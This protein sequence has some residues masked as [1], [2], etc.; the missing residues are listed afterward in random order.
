MWDGR[1]GHSLVTLRADHQKR[2][3][4]G[5]PLGFLIYILL[6]YAFT[7]SKVIATSVQGD[8]KGH[9]QFLGGQS[10]CERLSVPC[11]STA[12]PGRTPCTLGQEA[13]SAPFQGSVLQALGPWA[14]YDDSSRRAENFA[15]NAQGLVPSGMRLWFRYK[16]SPKSQPCPP[17]PLSQRVPFFL[18]LFPHPTGLS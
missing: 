8:H 4:T 1:G 9:T 6:A 15:A 5:N 3:L 11:S 13:R 10:E 12:A 16:L 2:T 7:Y 17:F 18:P 14:A